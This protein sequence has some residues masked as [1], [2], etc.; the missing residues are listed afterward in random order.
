MSFVQTLLTLTESWTIT[1]PESVHDLRN[2][3]KQSIQPRP[4]F[5]V[6]SRL[7]H[8]GTVTAD[9]FAIHRLDVSNFSLW[10]SS[11]TVAGK[12]REQDGGTEVALRL[13]ESGVVK[14]FAWLLLFLAIATPPSVIAN[15][16]TNPPMTGLPG[17]SPL[18]QGGMSFLIMF[19][20]YLFFVVAG[21]VK[22]RAVRRTITELVTGQ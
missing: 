10:R 9:G 2:R 12:F 19:S 8:S 20:V 17:L 6:R 21:Y 14:V 3:L 13:T 22:L 7:G 16:E 18:A 1:V 11:I 15:S 4:I 5:Q